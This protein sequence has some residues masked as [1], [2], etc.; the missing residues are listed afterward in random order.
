MVPDQFLEK[1]DIREPRRPGAPERRSVRPEL[2][3]FKAPKRG[4]ESPSKAAPDAEHLRMVEYREFVES[5]FSRGVER[6]NSEEIGSVYSSVETKVSCLKSVLSP[7]RFKEAL[8]R[9]VKEELGKLI[10]IPDF[11]SWNAAT[12]R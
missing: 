4:A 5:E 10:G 6:L 2:K 8:E 1:Q 3:I 7:D 9:C 11:K 12:K